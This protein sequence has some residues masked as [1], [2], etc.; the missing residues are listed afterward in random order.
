MGMD[1]DHNI[2]E[3]DNSKQQMVVW[4]PHGAFCGVALMFCGTLWQKQSSPKKGWYVVIADLLF[5]MP[6]LGEFLVVSNCRSANK[7]TMQA[8]LDEGHTIAVQPGGIYEQVRWSHDREVAYFPERLGFIRLAIQ[9]GIPLLP[10]YIFGEG[11]LYA[12]NTV[13]RA[14]NDLIYRATG[15]GVFLTIGR[16]GVPGIWPRRV[17][18]RQFFGR[19]V[20]VGPAQSS[21][22]DA[23]VEEVF[24]RYVAALREVWDANASSWLPAPIVK[25]GLTII[26][27]GHEDR[28]L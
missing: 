12:Q 5:R 23:Q 24:L 4:H 1:F 15:A 9:R 27:R 26:W 18:V 28:K 25:K 17:P 3:V 13:T 11:Q 21:P 8:L 14:V 7:G 19:S 10:A 20:D 16:W 6:G 2:D 22:S